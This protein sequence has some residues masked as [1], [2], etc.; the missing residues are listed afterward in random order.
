M[1][2]EEIRVVWEGP[3]F[4]NSSLGLVNRQIC[5]ELLRHPEISL[6]IMPT[7]RDSI[8]ERWVSTS[9]ML[10]ACYQKELGPVEVHVRHQWPPRLIPP[11]ANIHILFQPWEFGTVP[12]S[13]VPFIREY[14]NEVWVYSR[15]TKDGYIRSTI[16]EEKIFV[17]PLGVD[18]E[19]FRPDGTCLKLKTD[20]RFKF[21]F[22]GGTIF[23]KGI[24]K[25]L[26]A[27]ST[28][29][30]DKDD[31]CLVIKDQGVQTY[32]KGQTQ[33]TRIRELQQM[34]NAPEILYLDEEMDPHELA[35]LYR[36]CDCLVHPYRGEGFGLPILEAMAS[37]V[38]PIIP[39]LGSALDFTDQTTS[40]RISAKIQRVSLETL[41]TVLPA[42]IIDVDT[43]HLRV[44]MRSAFE[45]PGDVAQMGQRA[46]QYARQFSWGNTGDIVASRLQYLR[47]NAKNKRQPDLLQHLASSILRRIEAEWDT[48]QVTYK[49]FLKCFAPGDRI[50]DFGTADDTWIDL[51]RDYGANGYRVRG[52]KPDCLLEP[53]RAY[54][55]VLNDI[56]SFE[57]TLDG[58]SMFDVIQRF[59][60]PQV[61]R[62]FHAIT[63]KMTYR[64]RILLTTPHM[65]NETVATKEFWRDIR[66]V[67]PYPLELLYGLLQE[68][69]F[70]TIVAGRAKQD[71]E[72]IL[73]ASMMMNDNPFQ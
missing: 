7:E 29:F 39:E 47:T 1:S 36:A 30:S 5:F 35:A 37:G 28:T 24:D 10:K 9:T 33:Q 61:I 18:F 8:P 45:N 38:P 56:R 64:G 20:K 22:V 11:N 71:K 48:N 17:V 34:P 52:M 73:F 50:L 53:E 65:E 69:G 62:L 27:Y 57:G 66:N 43:D 51:L 54:A 68:C 4:V 58:V 19:V 21:L 26:D 16:P 31:V 41:D 70:R 42:E 13:W 2:T 72:I 3:Q 40:Y 46:F 14:V 44:V 32:Y 25:L 12:K 55:E 49:H 63:V 23:R 15:Y 59:S 67:R 60:V 6:K